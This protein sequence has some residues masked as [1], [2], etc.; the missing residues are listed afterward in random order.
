[1]YI[2]ELLRTIDK[3]LVLVFTIIFLKNSFIHQGD[4]L[5]KLKTYCEHF[6]RIFAVL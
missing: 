6:I 5:K 3:E 1:M 2:L 4:G